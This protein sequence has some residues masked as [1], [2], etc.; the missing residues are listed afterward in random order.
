MSGDGAG[1]KTVYLRLTRRHLGRCTVFDGRSERFRR[2]RCGSG[3][4]RFFS[5]GATRA[6]TYLLPHA[7]PAGHYVLDIEAVARGSQ[8]DRRL[9]PGGSRVTFDV[10]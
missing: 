8:R 7:L 4:A 5:I 3:P 1:L 9:H 2:H 6:F 10:R